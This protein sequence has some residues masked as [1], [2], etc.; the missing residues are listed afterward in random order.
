MDEGEGCVAER[1]SDDAEVGLEVHEL[2][3]ADEHEEQ[4][5]QG[6]GE[7]EA[8][9]RQRVWVDGKEGRE[10]KKERTIEAK[11]AEGRC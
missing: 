2:E 3:G 8:S 11:N 6:G 4:A 9:G 1:A 10:G 7:G 5:G